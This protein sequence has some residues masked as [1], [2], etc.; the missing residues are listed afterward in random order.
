MNFLTSLFGFLKT[1]N[2]N[3]KKANI[4]GGTITAIGT[5]CLF[6]V[7]DQY[8]IVDQ[9]I[10]AACEQGK[11][12]LLNLLYVFVAGILVDTGITHVTLPKPDDS[13]EDRK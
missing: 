6:G 8:G 9:I 5:A 3:P 11:D 4:T 10:V 2:N 7:A 12:G 13:K 1:L